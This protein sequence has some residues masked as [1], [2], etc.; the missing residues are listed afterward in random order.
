MRRGVWWLLLGLVALGA[1]AEDRPAPPP[2]PVKLAGDLYE[3]KLDLD[4]IFTPAVVDK[5]SSG[6]TTRIV[7]RAQVLDAETGAVRSLS[8]VEYRI[9]YV[10]WEEYYIVRRW[11]PVPGEAVYRI[12]QRSDVLRRVGKV[13]H[14]PLAGRDDLTPGKRYVALVNVVV[15]PISEEL[16]AKVREYLANPGG[17]RR[18]GGSRGLFGNLARIFFD[19]ATGSGQSALELRSEPFTA[20]AGK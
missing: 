13:E 1:R 10:V 3:A 14:L 2:F 11:T 19:P 9:L 8:V 6:I 15:D 17:S 12:K 16:L 5:I 7:L 20:Q 18:E 4:P